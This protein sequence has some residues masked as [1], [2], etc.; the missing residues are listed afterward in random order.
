MSWIKKHV[1]ILGVARVLGLQIRHRKARCWRVENHRHGDADPSLSFI[2]KHNRCRCFVCDMKGGHSNLDLVMGV[3]DCDFGAAVLWIAERFPVPNVRAGRP[4]GSTLPSAMPYRV[5]VH[6]SEWEIIVRSGM[7]GML[8]AAERSILLT[9]DEWRDVDTGLTRLSYRAIM[10]YS[11]VAK[12]GNVSS[13]I[14]ELKRIHAL[15]S[16]PGLRCGLVRECSTYRVTLTDPK[17]LE[18]CNEIYT[19]ARREIAQEREY[20]ACQKAKRQRDAHKSSGPSLQVVTQNTNT[21]G[22]LRPPDH[23]DICV[24][25]SKPEMQS[26]EAPTCEGLNL[27]SPGEV[28]ANK[29]L[30]SG[31]REIGFSAVQARISV[32]EQKRILREKGFLQ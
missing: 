23:S 31:K 26:Q 5:G 13:A 15:Q 22:G 4:A 21:A 19:S 1:P 14:K 27:S 12:P 28:H 7:W 24:S 17:F 32:E 2:A 16:V 6:G 10:R 18:I 11:G 20:R 8:S 30:P 29:A 9:L 3:L 25:N